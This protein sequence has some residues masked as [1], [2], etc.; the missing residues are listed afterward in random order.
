MIQV[1]F[2]LNGQDV[3][4]NVDAKEILT[5]T[6]R[7]RFGLTGTK[8]AC[9]T[10]DCGACT[11]LLDGVAVRSCIT[12]TAMVDGHEVTTI[13]GVGTADHLHPVQQAYID[14]G[15]VQC[16][17]CTPGMVLSSIALLRVNPHPTREEIRR[18]LSGNLCRC[19]GYHKIFRAVLRAAKIERQ[20]RLEGKP[21]QLKDLPGVHPAPSADRL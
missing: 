4:C 21:S 7:N 6:I 20:L 3:S 1:N 17:Y 13:E 8:K 16:G 5:D 18:G 9:G 14:A 15:A 11:V 10:G 2:R 19:T 12:L